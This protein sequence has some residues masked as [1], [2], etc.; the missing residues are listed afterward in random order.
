MDMGKKKKNKPNG[1]SY[2]VFVVDI[3][4]GAVVHGMDDFFSYH[5]NDLGMKTEEKENKEWIF[6]SICG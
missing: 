2:H 6:S 1:S 5:K 4:V 3:V